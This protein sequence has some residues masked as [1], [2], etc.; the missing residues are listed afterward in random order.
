[1]SAHCDNCQTSHFTLALTV[2]LGFW[3]GQTRT[4]IWSRTRT[5][6]PPGVAGWESEL[7]SR[8]REV[9]TSGQRCQPSIPSSRRFRPVTRVFARIRRFFGSRKFLNV[10]FLFVGFHFGIDKLNSTFE[11]SLRIDSWSQVLWAWYVLNQLFG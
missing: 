7:T 10:G 3:C 5:H 9:G 2:C 11:F 8:V 1:M 6:P 4:L